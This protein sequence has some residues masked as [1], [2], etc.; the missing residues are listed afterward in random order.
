MHEPR[1]HGANELICVKGWCWMIEWDPGKCPL[2]SL[3]SQYLFLA[4]FCLNMATYIEKSATFYKGWNI[5][6]FLNTS[7]FTCIFMQI[8]ANTIKYSNMIKYVHNVIIHS[9]Y[10][11]TNLPNPGTPASE[12]SYC[13]Q[14]NPPKKKHSPQRPVCVFNQ[15]LP[16]L[17]P[18]EVETSPSHHHS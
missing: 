14:N 15:V 5:T 1:S 12:K 6:E 17:D 3:G 2:V 4:F 7:I 11:F 9:L 8:H 13:Q 18:T 10:I 16:P